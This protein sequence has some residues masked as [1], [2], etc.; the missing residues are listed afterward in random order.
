[1]ARPREFDNVEALDRIVDTFWTKGYRKTTVD[2]LI[3]ATGLGR[4]SLYNAFGDKRRIFQQALERYRSCSGGSVMK[5]LHTER[6]ANALHAFFDRLAEF[7]DAPG[8][9]RGCLM[10]NTGI[11][12]IAIDAELQAFIREHFENMGRLFARAVT[13][14][15]DDGV[16]LP[17]VDPDD[18]GIWL[19]TFVRGVLASAASGTQ[20]KVLKKSIEITRQQWAG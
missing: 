10:V 7:V 8:A 3:E 17:A 12:S 1:M 5:P 11:E 16:S 6:G 14:A 9:S 13:E 18:A 20:A 2:D 19:V 15:R 4:S